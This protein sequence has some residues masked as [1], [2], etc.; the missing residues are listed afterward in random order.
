VGQC[1]VYVSLMS[2][3]LPIC[4]FFFSSLIILGY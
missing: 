4:F 3:E 2:M 1:L